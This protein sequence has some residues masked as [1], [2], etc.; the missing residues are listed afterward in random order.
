M[1]AVQFIENLDRTSLTISDEDFEKNVEAAVSAIAER[2]SEEESKQQLNRPPPSPRLQPSEK[3]AISRPEVTPRNSLEAEQSTPRRST[4]SRNGAKS[5]SEGE[6]NAAMTVLRTI[7]RPLSTIGRIFSDEG[8]TSNNAQS[9]T[10]PATTPRLSPAPRI[11]EAQP[12]RSQEQ[13][14][15]ENQRVSAED[16]AARQASAEAEQARKIRAREEATVV[17]TLSGMFPALDKEIILYVVRA[18]EGR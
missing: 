16:A 5:D 17:E 1:G 3:S 2:H 15:Q 8:S 13:A 4:S 9:T 7:Q 6:E 18:N 14:L 11:E 12:R 10:Q